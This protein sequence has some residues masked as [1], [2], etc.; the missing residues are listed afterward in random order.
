MYQGQPLN[1]GLFLIQSNRKKCRRRSASSFYI[2]R[3]WVLF[4]YS[5]IQQKS[6]LL[7]F[8]CMLGA[9]GTTV[10]KQDGSLPPQSSQSSRENGITYLIMVE[11]C[12]LQCTT[13]KRENTWLGRSPWGSDTSTYHSGW[14]QGLW[15]QN[16]WVGLLALPLTSCVTLGKLQNFSGSSCPRL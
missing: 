5:L 12:V 4:T 13:Y 3:N 9:G 15:R 14:K 2:L 11:W 16:A 7:S 6:R 8:R 1:S 10:N